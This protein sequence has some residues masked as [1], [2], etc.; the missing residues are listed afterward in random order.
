M[1]NTENTNNTDI[2][3]LKAKIAKK[4][5]IKKNKKQTTQKYKYIQKYNK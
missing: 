2:I 3:I 1:Q 5:R 4:T